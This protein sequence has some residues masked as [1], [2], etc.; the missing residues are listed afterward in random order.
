M[1]V[2]FTFLKFMVHFFF[3]WK[4]KVFVNDHYLFTCKPLLLYKIYLPVLLLVDIQILFSQYLFLLFI[5][6]V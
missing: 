5:Y 1:D 6:L 3:I 2:L 4:I